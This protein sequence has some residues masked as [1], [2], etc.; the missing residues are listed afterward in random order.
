MPVNLPPVVNV[1]K[2]NDPSLPSRIQQPAPQPVLNTPKAP[3][4][5]PGGP[6]NKPGAPSA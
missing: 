3:A 6:T 5:Q 4:M 1:P 2:T